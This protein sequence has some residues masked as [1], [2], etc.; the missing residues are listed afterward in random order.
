MWILHDITGYLRY[1]YQ[2]KVNDSGLSE[3]FNRTIINVILGIPN[4]KPR[5]FNQRGETTKKKKRDSTTTGPSTGPAVAAA[6]L[7]TSHFSATV[8]SG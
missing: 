7:Q 5:G 2:K 6:Q 3:A 4:K 1:N 8:A